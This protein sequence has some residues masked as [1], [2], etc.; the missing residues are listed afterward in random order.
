MID[1]ST[2]PLE[3]TGDTT[4]AVR[5]PTLTDRLDMGSYLGLIV[6]APASGPVV[7]TA[8]RELRRSTS[9]GAAENGGPLTIDELAACFNRALGSVFF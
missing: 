7:V 2:F 8:A 3:L 1:F 5:R 6:P 9:F 4:V